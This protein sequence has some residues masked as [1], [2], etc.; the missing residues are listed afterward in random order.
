MFPPCPLAPV[1]SET[2]GV[3]LLQ[4]FSG[5]VQ[6]LVI[7]RTPNYLAFA[8]CAGRSSHCPHWATKPRK[9][10]AVQASFS[11]V[12]GDVIS[13]AGVTDTAGTTFP[14]QDGCV[15]TAQI[16]ASERPA[17]YLSFLWRESQNTSSLT[18]CTILLP[19]SQ[20]GKFSSLS[21]LT[22]ATLASLWVWCVSSLKNKYRHHLLQSAF[23]DCLYCSHGKSSVPSLRANGN[24]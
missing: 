21:S 12:I 5:I 19:K 20:R 9:A 1:P 8:G 16:G 18:L 3:D 7:L 10:I 11:D 14:F 2:S 23:A 4:V 17:I 24:P 22:V 6:G 13:Q 15:L